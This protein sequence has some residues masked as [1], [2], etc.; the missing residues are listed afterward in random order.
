MEQRSEATNDGADLP[1][2]FPREVEDSVGFHLLRRQGASDAVPKGR[3]GRA[4]AGICQLVA[5]FEV[6]GDPAS[7]SDGVPE[8]DRDAQNKRM[9]RRLRFASIRFGVTTEPINPY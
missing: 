1:A 9:R 5:E 6:V 8:R 7:E 2:N 4:V 3:G